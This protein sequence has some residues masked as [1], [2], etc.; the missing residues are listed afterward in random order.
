MLTEVEWHPP[1]PVLRSPVGG[2][3]AGA[4]LYDFC[5]RRERSE[6]MASPEPAKSIRRL[7]M[8]VALR[9]G[10]GLVSVL[11]AFV[12]AQT[13]VFYHLPQP[14]TAFALSTIAGAFWYGGSRPRMV[15]VLIFW[16]GRDCCLVPGG[17]AESRP[18]HARV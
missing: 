6:P 12:V 11:L 4:R 13:F 16:L 14:F 17:N 15:T 18:L 1:D 8:P 5:G 2:I 7:A 3:S 10:L 9:W